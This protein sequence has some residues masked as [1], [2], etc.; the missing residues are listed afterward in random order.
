MTAPLPYSTWCYVCGKDNP[1]GLRIVFRSD[2]R[3]VTAEFT[4]DDARQGYPGRVHGGVLCA[5]LDETMGWAP[6]LS[7]RRM[8]VTAELTVRFVKPAPAGRLLR[9]TGRC[10]EAGRRLHGTKGRHVDR[11]LAPRDRDRAVD[12]GEV[13]ARAKG[14]YAPLSAGETA[15]VDRLLLYDP[16]TL[17]LFE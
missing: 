12:T 11:S 5:L 6:T 16:D 17:R 3:V 10:L 2:G 9:V 8:C 1:L 14:T 4:A 13:V 15:A 7:T